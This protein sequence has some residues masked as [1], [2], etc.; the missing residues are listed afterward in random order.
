MVR[1]AALLV[2]L[3]TAALATEGGGT[4]RLLGLE[5]ILSG[6]MPPPGTRFSVYATY[7]DSH[8]LY[9]SDGRPRPGLSDFDLRAGG[10]SVR[11]QH[12]WSGAELW[13]ASI[14]TRL[15]LGA[16]SRADI[17]FDV[18]TPAGTIHRADS[19][20][21]YGDVIL[22]PVLLGWHGE[23]FHQITGLQFFLPTGKFDAE[24]LVNPGRGY[25]TVAPMYWFT[26]FPADRFEASGTLAYLWNS[27][28]R[29]TKYTSGRELG[30]DWGVGYQLTPALQLGAS[31]YL[32]KQVTDDE[33]AGRV[34]GDGNRGQGAAAGPSVRYRG[35]SWGVVLKWQ[36]EFAIENRAR[37]DRFFVQ[38]T[39]LVQ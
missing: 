32:Y 21:G 19:R 13:G 26:W 17:D 22:A 11:F 28:N 12:V 34:F 30:F 15:G 10:S 14:E 18:Q 9:G 20:G 7:Y 27:E 25:Y 2:L 39:M 24:R 37:G 36:R 23:Q 35:S 8:D 5:T 4:A 16:Y 38:F 33:I 3:P 1:W 6:V 29:E 31:G